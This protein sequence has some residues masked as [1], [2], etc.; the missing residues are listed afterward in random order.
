MSQTSW[1]LPHRARGLGKIS[2][3]SLEIVAA[4]YVASPRSKSVLGLA[5]VI[6][7]ATKSTVTPTSRSGANL[8]LVLGFDEHILYVRE[9]D[10]TPD[11]ISA[12]ILE[13]ATSHVSMKYNNHMGE[14]AYCMPFHI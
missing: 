1:S 2:P 6:V 12:N 3:T 10:I 11:D 5:T 4:H 9:L 8:W 14:L 13:V 7:V